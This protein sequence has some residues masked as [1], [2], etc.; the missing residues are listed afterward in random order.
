[1]IVFYAVFVCKLFCVT[2]KLKLCKVSIF[3]SYCFP[4]RSQ[5]HEVGTSHSYQ[6]VRFRC[7]P[8]RLVGW[9]LKQ[10]TRFC[11]FQQNRR[12]NGLVGSP[13][14]H[15][16]FFSSSFQLTV[17]P[18]MSRSVNSAFSSELNSHIPPFKRHS[19]YLCFFWKSENTSCTFVQINM[20]ASYEKHFATKNCSRGN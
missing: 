10:V 14:R 17:Q 5:L 16:T 1:M 18:S 8:Q 20:A 7:Q 12:P 4:F 11:G 19:S 9:N 13:D 3:Q 6:P 15:F 2:T